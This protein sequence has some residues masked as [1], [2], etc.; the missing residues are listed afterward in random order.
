MK[1]TLVLTLIAGLGCIGCT[2][3]A[4]AQEATAFV[5]VVEKKAAP[6]NS[7]TPGSQ[8]CSQ[9]KTRF[10]EAATRCTS[11]LATEKKPNYGKCQT[12]CKSGI[13]QAVSTCNTCTQAAVLCKTC[14]K[15]K[16]DTQVKAASNVPA[17]NLCE[18]LAE[19][20]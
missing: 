12:E 4:T 19:P 13:E 20:S 5:S 14:A 16:E 10:N 15:S 11:C 1:T 3:M 2:H 8:T 9:C 6:C 18:A 7:C 17:C